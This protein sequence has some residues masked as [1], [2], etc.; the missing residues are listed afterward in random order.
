M[1]M[2]TCQAGWECCAKVQGFDLS[3]LDES[4]LVH[5]FGL[6]AAQDAASEVRDIKTIRPAASWQS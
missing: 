6:K 2:G 1:S 4:I 3:V 5:K